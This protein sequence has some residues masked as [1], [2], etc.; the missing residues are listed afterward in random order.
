MKNIQ[1]RQNAVVRFVSVYY[2]FCFVLF[3][4]VY[5][6][7]TNNYN[8]Y[9]YNS[10]QVTVIVYKKEIKR[11]RKNPQKYYGLYINN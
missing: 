10:L 4:F 8:T 3:C 1:V 6:A 9:I 11:K 5:F 7:H 2:S